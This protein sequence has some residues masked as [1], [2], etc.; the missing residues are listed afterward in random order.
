MQ[1]GQREWC[2]C[3]MHGHDSVVG[4]DA[5]AIRSIVVDG[6]AGVH[7]PRT[8]G[9]TGYCDQH[10][11]VCM[12]PSRSAQD[13][14]WF[15]LP[16]ATSVRRGKN[17]FG[18]AVGP[19]ERNSGPAEISGS[20]S[21]LTTPLSRCSKL[22][23]IPPLASGSK[24]VAVRK[25]GACAGMVTSR[26]ALAV[27]TMLPVAAGASA[28]TRLT[29][30]RI[31]QVVEIAQIPAHPEL[32][33]TEKCSVVG[34]GEGV[35]VFAETRGLWAIVCFAHVHQVFVAFN[36]LE[37]GGDLDHIDPRNTVDQSDDCSERRS[38]GSAVLSGVLTRCQRP[39]HEACEFM[40]RTAPRP[41]LPGFVARAG[42]I[43]RAR[44]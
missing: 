23:V 7:R 5:T 38:A 22:Y 39:Q 18:D 40:F 31:L 15:V 13:A 3:V 25:N 26:P 44:R 29:V 41:V 36:D 42:R 17:E 9:R 37:S 2:P 28:S 10:N 19:N 14:F 8:P 27:G 1:C 35:A 4:V 32:V 21:A 30:V 24:L 43:A 34:V 6:R 11:F 12:L 16:A 20:F 33:L